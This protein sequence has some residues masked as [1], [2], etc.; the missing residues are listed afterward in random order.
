MNALG[1]LI[2]W[3]SQGI[4]F[5]GESEKRKGFPLRLTFE[6]QLQGLFVP[7]ALQFHFLAEFGY[8][9]SFPAGFVE[10]L[11]E[12]E[13]GLLFAVDEEDFFEFGFFLTA[14][15]VNHFAVV[16]V[17]REG[18][19]ASEFSTY[20]VTVAEDGDG[21]VATHNF[22]SESFGFAVADA[23]NGGGGVVDVVGEVVLDTTGFHHAGG[24]DDDARFVADVE[25]FGGL[26]GLDVLQAVEAK[27][28]GVF[29]H[30]VEDGRAEAFAVKA[31]DVGGGDAE[32][33]VDK[34]IDVG[35]EV[36]GFESVE[37][38]DDFLCAAN[39]EGWDDEFAF[40]FGAGV[41]DGHEEFFLGVFN[42][43]VET[44][45]VG[46]F[47]DEVVDLG[48][49]FGIFEDSFVVAAYVAGEA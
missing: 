12:V 30:V 15:I 19:D 9:H 45:A 29:F 40:L 28:V 13:L 24:G 42:G 6:I 22:G 20:F 44:V 43:G 48:E 23:E 26:D 32:G 17:A 18:F 25:G 14:D 1:F 37:G 47:H 11:F 7:W 10:G 35:E 34:D 46:G 21:F 36:G 2:V 27:G 41:E 8:L 49:G 3:D 33:A 39:G 31:E 16:A 4:V 5:L 38:I